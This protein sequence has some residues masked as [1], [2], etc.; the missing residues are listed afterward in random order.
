MLVGHFAV[1]F[2]G[3]RLE[4]KLSLGTLVFAA[5]LPD[6][7]WPI[8][9]LA[10]LEYTARPGA[11]ASQHGFD[12]PVSHSL[13]TVLI[14]AVLFSGGYLL[15][16]RYGRG[17]PSKRD[18]L[19]LFGA[20]LSHWLLDAVSYRHA[21]APGLNRHVGLMLWNSVP[22]TLLV[23]GGL[24]L[25]AIVIY[26][27]ATRARN[28]AGLYAFWPVVTF[29][30]FVWVANIRKGPPPP[31]AVAGSLIFFILLVAWAYWMNRA[32]PASG[33]VG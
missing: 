21:L 19:V 3:K 9:S 8:F 28:W 16:R 13:L 23:E 31:E 17:E 25:F 5:M 18:A 11:G 26:L 12:A 20:V 6:V 33:L 14:W 15:W 27:R 22:A 7:L 30:T 1:A 4:P 32:R 24:W 10:G 2:A 29:L